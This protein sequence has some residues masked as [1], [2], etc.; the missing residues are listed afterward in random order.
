MIL[1]ACLANLLGST[2]SS[3]LSPTQDI[4]SDPGYVSEEILGSDWVFTVREAVIVCDN[5]GDGLVLLR[6]EKGTF[7][8]TGYSETVGYINIRD[9]GIWKTNSY[10]DKIPAPGFWNYVWTLCSVR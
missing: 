3:S 2:L 6:T 7:G 5:P 8:L 10:G 4:R 9:S 1:I